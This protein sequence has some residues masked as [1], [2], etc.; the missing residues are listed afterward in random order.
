MVAKKA[1]WL[2]GEIG[3]YACK[4]HLE[5]TTREAIGLLSDFGENA[6]PRQNQL[7]FSHDQK[8]MDGAE[9]AA[10]SLERIASIAQENGWVELAKG[11]RENSEKIKKKLKKYFEIPGS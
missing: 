11:A 9:G 2:A 6:A 10:E 1:I 3:T 5:W 4:N 8:L 7:P